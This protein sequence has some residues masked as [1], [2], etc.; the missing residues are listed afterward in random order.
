[1]PCDVDATVIANTRLSDDYSVLALAAPEIA[2]LARPGQFVMVKATHSADPLLRR[3]F[4]IFEIL[5]DATGAPTGVSLLN[6]RIGT[7]TR[8]LYDA[9]PGARVSC[10]GP[11]GRPFEPVDGP[12]HAWMVA[13][14]VGLAPFLTLAESLA[15]RH[16]PT[17]LF[18]GA[19]H[20]GELYYTDTFARLGIVIE[21][22][23]EDGSR[24]TKGYVTAPL[25]RAFTSLAPGES[26]RL[27]VCGPTAMMRAVAALSRTYGQ[28][29]EVS[30]EQ[31][32][33]C[34]LGGCYSCVVLTRQQPGA[35]PHFVRSC[36][37]GPVFD[38]ERIV[39]E[40][41]TH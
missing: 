10:L 1:V 37:D 18:Y 27:Y 5:R 4:S 8:L 41:L 12:V 35:T 14:G 25:E 31:V 7:A 38:A 9:A 36:L 11:L 6:K 28:P 22:A 29:C 15:A 24:G 16:T 20:A 17:T 39:W 19:R 26:V 30:L 33:G 40:A 3:P 13:G 2:G 21:L 23:T 32:M 34:G